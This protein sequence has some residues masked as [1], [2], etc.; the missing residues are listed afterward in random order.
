MTQTSSPSPAE[1]ARLKIVDLG[2]GMPA[3]LVSRLLMNFGADVVRI[4]PESGDPFYR[5]YPAYEV[6]QRGKEIR[7][8]APGRLDE[9]HVLL[10]TADA[11]LLGGEDFPGLERRVDAGSLAGKHPHLVILEI[12]AYPEF[13]AD[14]E[15]P[16]VDVLVQARSGL[17]YEHYSDRP[18]AMSFEPCNYGS[19]LQGL[20]GLLAALFERASSGQGQIVRTSLYEGALTWAASFWSEASNPT[21]AFSFAVPR[22][23]WPLIF[24]CK[25]GRYIHIVLGSSGSKARLY[26]ILGIDDPAI[27]AKDSG[28][29]RLV[30]GST[31][32]KTF[33]GD[34]ELLT[35]YIERRDSAELLEA[36]WAAGLAADYVQ[37]PGTCWDDPQ[38]VHNGI[39][40]RDPDGTRRVGNPVLAHFTSS[41]RAT[42]QPAGSG[43]LS[44]LRVVDFGTFVAGPYSS[45]LLA[46]LGADVIK[47]EA[48][49]GDPNR[50]VFRSFT[51]ANR[52]KRAIMVDLKAP[53][54]REIAQ[55]LCAGADIVTNNFRTGVAARLGIDAATLHESRP[56]LIVLES[57]AYGP[58]GPKS[59]QAGFDLVFQA[60]CGHEYRAGGVGNPP[61][62]NRTTLVDYAGG[63][64]G[65]CAILHALMVRARSGSGA[66]LNVPLINAGIFLMSELVQRPDGR[67]AGA[68]QLNSDQTGYHPAERMYQTRDGWIAIA[69]R[70]EAAAHRL[71]ALTGMEPI[72]RP[73]AQWGP[74]EAGV[75]GAVIRQQTSEAILAQL[76][77]ADIWAEACVP[78]AAHPTLNDSGLARN[79]TVMRS[80]HP[81]FG[82]VREIG[83]LFRLSRSRCA[84][85]DHT[86]LPGEHTRIVLEELGYDDAQIDELKADKIIA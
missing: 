62:W 41:T 76:A 49:I 4:E 18:I 26:S 45:V 10:A 35:G 67:F 43:P 48:P 40:E 52:G 16:A 75:I 29:P 44:G 9:I 80:K 27:D 51:T 77:A 7:R 56:D 63:L 23:P 24:R 15:R 58:T 53:A 34:V 8:L 11:C 70:G 33:F 19:A 5:T 50:N 46:D 81:Q 78:E 72:A 3:A 1:T 39:I 73:A 30:P 55:K 42:V 38:V 79:G 59:A 60:L 32:T 69:A 83:P 20:A 2:T 57:A 36:L 64:L 68:P 65:A 47:V 86:P 82:D 71:A 25:D 13:L 61:L 54:G 14:A 85:H 6:W 84:G 22:D 37:P 31:N 66:R 28:M 74:A 12:D 17:C 21:P